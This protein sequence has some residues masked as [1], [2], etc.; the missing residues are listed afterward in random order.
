MQRR[1]GAL[2]E[3]P[4]RFLSTLLMMPPTPLA[5]FCCCRFK[6]TLDL[7]E[8][9]SL[10]CFICRGE[11]CSPRKNTSNVWHA[12]FS[13]LWLS[14]VSHMIRSD[15]FCSH[16]RWGMEDG[17]LINP[18]GNIPARTVSLLHW[19]LKHPIIPD[20]PSV[21]TSIRIYRVGKVTGNGK[22]VLVFYRRPRGDSSTRCFGSGHAHGLWC[23][24]TYT[25]HERRRN[26]VKIAL[27][28][29]ETI[30]KKVV[31]HRR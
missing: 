16:S 22:P 15:L 31:I 30:H 8:A 11:K 25:T 2:R 13:A 24:F 6:Q 27:C 9:T 19:S 18:S 28:P 4:L 10:S 3:M 1:R 29:E 17:E 7:L 5:E 21:R 26:G 12:P 20:P 23:A 14:F